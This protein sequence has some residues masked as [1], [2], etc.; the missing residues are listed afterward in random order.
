LG[1]TYLPFVL[2]G[3]LQSRPARLETLC[4]LPEL[5]GVGGNGR[6]GRTAIHRQTALDALG[7]SLASRP[8]SGPLQRA[9]ATSC[10]H[11]LLPR[12]DSFGGPMAINDH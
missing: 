4:P 12:A 6:C 10:P 3:P 5:S 2:A 9:R 11:V 8:G 7:S 1:K